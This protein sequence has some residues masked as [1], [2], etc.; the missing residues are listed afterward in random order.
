MKK[1]LCCQGGCNSKAD[2]QKVIDFLKVINEPNRLKIVCFLKHGEQCVCEIWKKL[3]IPQNLTSHHLKALKEFG[4]IVSRQEGRKMIY[5]SNKEIISKY[6]A[7]LNNFLI[8]N[9]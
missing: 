9:L 4:I 5:S 6:A 7:L 3:E 2:F 1:N 8:A